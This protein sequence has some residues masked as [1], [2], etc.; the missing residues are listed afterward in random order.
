[1]TE[2]R[3]R[4]VILRALRQPRT[5]DELAL[6]FGWYKLNKILADFAQWGF[7]AYNQSTGKIE[8]IDIEVV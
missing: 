4:I 6:M 1:M 2:K 5:R 3:K 7:I 8:A